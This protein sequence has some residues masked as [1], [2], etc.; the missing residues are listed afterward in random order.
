M[1]NKPVWMRNAQ[2]FEE[3]AEQSFPA[4]AGGANVVPAAVN[5][6]TAVVTE[7]MSQASAN[8]QREVQL[9]DG[10]RRYRV[11]ARPG[12]ARVA[13]GAVNISGPTAKSV[14]LR[15]PQTL[16]DRLASMTLGQVSA[17]VTALLVHGL[18]RLA[19]QQLNLV[20]DRG[21]DWR[22]EPGTG[23]V[24]TGCRE[25]TE[26]AH[27]AAQRY[28]GALLALMDERRVGPRPATVAA[29][30]AYALDDIEARGL[31]LGLRVEAA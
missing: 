9:L 12:K 13:A 3:L 24:E 18:D 29:L 14:S 10:T 5:A 23:R 21:E 17:A 2:A 8:G 4:T 1:S 22:T 30:L 6:P 11:S 28:P 7:L 16:V 27:K 26:P 20:W 25:I 19:E 31:E 15:L